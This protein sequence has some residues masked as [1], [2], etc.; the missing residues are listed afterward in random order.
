MDRVIVQL[1]TIWL[2]ERMMLPELECHS[3]PYEKCWVE[4]F[5]IQ[6]ELTQGQRYWRTQQSCWNVHVHVRNDRM[7]LLKQEWERD[8]IWDR[9]SR[10]IDHD[11][12][13]RSTRRRMRYHDS[14]MSVTKW[15]TKGI[16]MFS[17][18]STT[19]GVNCRMSRHERRIRTP[20]D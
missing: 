12:Y 2:N 20:K 15:Y 11:S 13:D 6:K 7:M 19:K 5:P 9:S 18:L 3:I 17:R 16:S 10:H 14:Q 8:S 4:L 1:S